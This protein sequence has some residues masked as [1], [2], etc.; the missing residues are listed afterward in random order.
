MT[1]LKRLLVPSLIELVTSRQSDAMKRP[2]KCR[3]DAKH[4]ASWH[5]I[6]SIVPGSDI[7]RVAIADAP[8]YIPFSSLQIVADDPLLPSCDNTIDIDFE[9]P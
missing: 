1:V 2:H 4:R 6:A 3:L 8:W 5:A 9:I 7:P